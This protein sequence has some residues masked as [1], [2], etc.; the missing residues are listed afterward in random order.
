MQSLKENCQLIVYESQQSEQGDP[1]DLQ[2]I[3]SHRSLKAFPDTPTQ[4]GL[5]ARLFDQ[6]PTARS[7]EDLKPMDVI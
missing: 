1:A 5:I 4:D 2:N 3:M 7:N 6:Q